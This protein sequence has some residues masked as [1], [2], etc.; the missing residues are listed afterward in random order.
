MLTTEA[1]HN[2]KRGWLEGRYERSGSWDGAI[3]AD[4]N[5]MVLSA[6]LYKVQGKLWRPTPE[7]TYG[8]IRSQDRFTH[9]RKC[10][11]PAVQAQ[12]RQ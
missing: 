1:I 12:C 3:T 5:A 8:L 10:F 9:P 2:T 7:P 11:P 6:L 4:T